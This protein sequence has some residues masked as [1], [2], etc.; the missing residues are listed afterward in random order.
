MLSN[1]MKPGDSATNPSARNGAQP[2]AQAGK[3]QRCVT[4]VAKGQSIVGLV[5]VCVVF[6]FLS[7]SFLTPYNLFN[8]LR[9]SAVTGILAAG[10]VFVIVTGGIDLSVG[11]VVAVV[12]VITAGLLQ[13]GM[14]TTV[15]V[16]AGL[17]VGC[18]FGLANGFAIAVIRLPSFIVTLATMTIGSSIA[19]A[20][21]GGLPISGL[22]NA[23]T[24]I[25]QGM[26]GPVPVPVILAI[27]VATIAG[28]LLQRTLIGRFAIAIGSNE[29]VTFLSGVNTVKWKMVVYGL[30]GLLA[31]IAGVLLTARQNSG[32]PTAASG[33]ELTVIAAVVIGGTRLSG[34]RGSMWGAMVG[35]LLMTI[36]N[37]GLNLLN[38]SPYYQ[39]LF[40]GGLILIAVALDRRNAA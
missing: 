36:I 33:I 2:A 27:V 30:N 29:Q 10:M 12:G 14:P 17:L 18:V 5:I 11:A 24:W 28:V 22:P 23:F 6:S 1:N 31:G 32:Q 7:D 39:G 8:V 38:V 4:L 26:I 34:G 35:T 40:V 16:L 21:S 15:A 20:Y 3:W 25:G 13:G 19:L 37:N 9:Q